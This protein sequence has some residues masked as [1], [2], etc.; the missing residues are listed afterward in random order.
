MGGVRGG[1]AGVGRDEDAPCGDFGEK[2]KRG[3]E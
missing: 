3:R 1:K 2:G